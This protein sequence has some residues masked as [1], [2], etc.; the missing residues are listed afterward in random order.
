[1]VEGEGPIQN[2]SQKLCCFGLSQKLLISVVHALTCADF[3]LRSPGPK[4][5]PA[6][7]E[8]MAYPAGQ[9]PDL[10]PGRWPDV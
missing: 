8:A 6:D 5:A 3:I 1:M 10:W 7:P 2:L 4:M 9:T